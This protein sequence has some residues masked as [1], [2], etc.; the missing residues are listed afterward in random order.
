MISAVMRAAAA[1]ALVIASLAF[2]QGEVRAA[3]AVGVSPV[4][5]ATP[6]TATKP[7][8]EGA[9]P[10]DTTVMDPT[11]AEAEKFYDSL[12]DSTKRTVYSSVAAECDDDHDG[13]M[14][15]RMKAPSRFGI[16][17][18]YPKGYDLAKR[19]AK[20]PLDKQ[21]IIYGYAHDH[22]RRSGWLK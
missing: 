14:E 1:G 15:R 7:A 13:I 10:V 20:L 22:Q 4:A 9:A 8:G 17:R 5:E 12:A 2:T 18:L 21:Q 6:T 11:V 16:T 3:E 19:V